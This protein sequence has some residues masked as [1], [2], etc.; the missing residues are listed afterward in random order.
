MTPGHS[1]APIFYQDADQFGRTEYRLVGVCSCDNRD[2][3]QQT[4]G[5]WFTPSTVGWVN[6]A[7]Q[8]WSRTQDPQR[9]TVELRG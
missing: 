7:V 4:Y 8:R 2:N 1:G 9:T 3:P 5:T 6:R